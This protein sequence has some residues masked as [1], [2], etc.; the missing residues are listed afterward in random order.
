MSPK[1]RSRSSPIG[2]K[3]AI[4]FTIASIVDEVMII[5]SAPVRVVLDRPCPVPLFLERGDQ[6]LQQGRL[7][8]PGIPDDGDGA[9][10]H[11]ARAAS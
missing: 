7:P 6:P 9:R 2:G 4:R 5:V 11:D 10:F 3:A 8:C 1:V